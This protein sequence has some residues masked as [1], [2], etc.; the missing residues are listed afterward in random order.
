MKHKL[1]TRE[2][3]RQRITELEAEV[4][5]LREQL[6]QQ[7]ELTETMR[8]AAARAADTYSAARKEKEE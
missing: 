2:E 7:M 3:D 4:E 8:A 6:R 5:R 1:T